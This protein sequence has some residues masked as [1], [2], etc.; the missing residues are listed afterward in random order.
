MIIIKDN[1]ASEYYA[2]LCI[3]SWENLGFDIEKF[4]AITPNNFPNYNLN[5][6]NVDT[7]KYMMLNLTKEFTPTEKACFY[8]HIELWKKCIEL[9]ENI[10][11]I[12]HDNYLID[13]ELLISYDN[14]DFILYGTGTGAYIITPKFAKYLVDCLIQKFIKV[15]RGPLGFIKNQ[16]LKFKV[17]IFIPKFP[18]ID[19]IASIQIYNPLYGTTIKHYEGTSVEQHKHRFRVVPII[20]IKE[21]KVERSNM[22]MHITD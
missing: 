11:I 14:K 10:L 15:D 22:I 12:E 19:D 9:N 2:S 3:P 17:N 13:K 8:T 1:P 5:F 16:A 20:L 7:I 21:E 18:D 4:D 6:K